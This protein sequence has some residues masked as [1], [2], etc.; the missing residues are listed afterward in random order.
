MRRVDSGNPDILGL[1]L[2]PAGANVAVFSA[3]AEGVELCLFDRSGQIEIERI[4]LPE[5]TADVFHGFIPDIVAG[6]RYG[7]RAH[8]P[9][10]PPHGHRFNPSKL[11][12]D[13]YVKALDR[14]FELHA[15]M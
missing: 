10:D 13:P 9:Y 5:K 2:A 14:R 15:S 8:G 4:A 6:D 11:L 7:L 3:H 1:T 12:V